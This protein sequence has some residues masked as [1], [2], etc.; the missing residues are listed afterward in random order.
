MEVVHLEF[1]CVKVIHLCGGYAP[2]LGLRKVIGVS[3]LVWRLYT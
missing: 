2:L 1:T 3:S